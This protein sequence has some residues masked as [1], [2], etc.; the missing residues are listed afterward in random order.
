MAC[1]PADRVSAKDRWCRPAPICRPRSCW[2][3]SLVFERFCT[4]R[5]PVVVPGCRCTPARSA[6][7][8]PSAASGLKSPPAHQQSHPAFGCAFA[9]FAGAFAFCA[10]DMLDLLYLRLRRHAVLVVRVE[11]R[12]LPLQIALAQFAVQLVRPPAGVG[13]PFAAPPLDGEIVWLTSRANACAAEHQP[14]RWLKHRLQKRR[15]GSEIRWHNVDE[16][17]RR[18]QRQRP[19]C[20]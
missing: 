2:D 7:A 12:H 20:R 10:W 17:A 8:E 5:F 9:H 4:C 14:P 3:R 16:S 6:Q 1:N 15:V 13:A 11:S 18:T 19:S